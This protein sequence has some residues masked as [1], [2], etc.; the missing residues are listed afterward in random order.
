MRLA[1]N[2]PPPQCDTK[3]NT[4]GFLNENGSQFI[5]GHLL[6]KLLH[7]CNTSLLGKRVF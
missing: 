2:A 4:T 5:M 7:R 3:Q 1:S 6:N